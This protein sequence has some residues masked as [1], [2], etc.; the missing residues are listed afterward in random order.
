MY[1]SIVVG[2]D[3]SAGARLALRRAIAV[4]KAGH[5][6]AAVHVVS[7]YQP[8]TEPQIA[9][10]RQAL[11]APFRDEVQ[12]DMGPRAALAEASELLEA[13]DIEFLAY[14]PPGA[15][16]EAILAVAAEVGADLVLVGSHGLSRAAGAAGG[17]RTGPSMG[18][19]SARLV[20]D[21]PV[22]VLVVRNPVPAEPEGDAGDHDRE[23]VGSAF[24]RLSEAAGRFETDHPDLVRTV[25]DVSYYLSGLGL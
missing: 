17:G 2:T 9:Y 5:Q 7:A 24:G 21:S 23:T 13:A 25:S 12:P 16:A 18:Q 10:L 11:P 14:D 8:L 3:G 6:R 19:V 1:R 15:P 22:D 4:A 20:L